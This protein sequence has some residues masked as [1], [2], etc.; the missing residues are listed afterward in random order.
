[1]NDTGRSPVLI[2][3]IG[4]LVLQ[5][6]GFGVHAVSLLRS[7][8]RIDEPIDLL[9]GGTAG[10]HLMGYLRNYQRVIVVDAS[11]DSFPEGTVRRIRPRY[12]EFPPLVTAHEIGL[13]D[14]LEAMEI[15]GYCPDVE[16]I[17]ASVRKYTSLGTELSPSV[18][19]AL[20]KACEMALAAAR[21]SVA[22][23]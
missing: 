22:A 1:M 12:N 3:G 23:G 20:P 10:L 9:D 16:L 18:E 11:L 15:T 21:E 8:V 5:D 17:V 2:L 4:N 19:A 14:V 7:M 6:E 13:K